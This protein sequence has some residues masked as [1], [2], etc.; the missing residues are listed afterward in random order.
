[1]LPI[2]NHLSCTEILDEFE[3]LSY[4]QTHHA[5]SYVTGLAAASSKTCKGIAREVLPANSERA[6]NKFLTEYDWD[7]QQLNHERLE[8]LQE[9]GETRW[10]QDGN[11]VID[12]SVN[13]RT[14]EELP[15]V[16]RFYDHSEGETVW[17]QNLVYAFYTDD[18]T[19]YPLTVRQYENRDDEDEDETKYK[20]A[21]EIITELEEEVGVPADTYLFDA[22]FA[23]DSELI[24]HVE[25]YGKDWVGPLRSNRQV[26]Y[27]GEQMRVDALEERIDKEEREIDEETYK[28]WTQKRPISKLG[29]VKL[30]IAEKVTDDE[31]EANPVKYLATN[32]IDA[33][34][35]HVIRTYSYRWRIETFFE[36]SK[37]DLGLGDCEVRD[38]EGASRHWHLQMLT[39]SLLRLGSE[40]SASE[41]LTSK[42]SS[43]RAQLEHGLKEVVY[44]L[45]SWVRDQPERD[46]DG[47][48]E[49][50]DHLFLHS[51]GS[52]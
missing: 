36:D 33:P 9:D 24:K 4:H 42:A 16:G 6:L 48:M 1:M 11:I 41:R 10:S 15:G 43:L 34:S 25:S 26:T 19:A 2:T 7:E 27:A 13:Q 18:K 45:F 29:E 50:I 51:D 52:L 44:N 30:L 47:L 20:L 32:K 22:W 40:S 46:L 3:S 17:G 21:R 38:G 31:D 37:Q 12:D 14:G 8:K 23:H 49:E 28:I 5:K 39:Y 35:E